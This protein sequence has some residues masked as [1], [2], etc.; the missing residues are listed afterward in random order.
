MKV[1]SFQPKHIVDLVNEKTFLLADA[2]KGDNWEFEFPNG[3]ISEGFQ[4]PYKW[5]KE[6]FT[7]LRGIEVEGDL[8][9]AFAKRPDLRSWRYRFHGEDTVLIEL[10]IPEC[11]VLISDHGAWHSVLNGSH[12]SL[13]REDD[14]LFYETYYNINISDRKDFQRTVITEEIKA[15]GEELKRKSWYQ[16]F[17][18]EAIQSSE[19]LNGNNRELLLQA[20]FPVLRKEN[21]V[22]VIHYKPQCPKD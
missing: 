10:D 19:Y 8:W 16:I 2:S 15:Q 14:D 9:W 7:E 3:H 5:M 11:E 1:W 13:T 20:V 22:K 6:V 17:D 12:C 4:K 18:L 21:I